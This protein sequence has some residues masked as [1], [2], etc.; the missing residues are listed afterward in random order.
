[1]HGAFDAGPTL[2]TVGAIRCAL[3]LGLLV[4]GCRLASGQ[5]PVGSAQAA[6]FE[7]VSLARSGC[8]GGS[9]P[10]YSVT[11]MGDGTV[12]Y[13]GGV[14]VKTTGRQHGRLSPQP[15]NA[16]TDENGEAEFVV[17]GYA[18][19]EDARE[20]L[21]WSTSPPRFAQLWL[22]EVLETPTELGNITLRRVSPASVPPP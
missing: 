4:A 13:E 2:R 16:R 8:R 15:G 11:V 21:L 1:M 10:A 7:R 14:Y 6:A 5:G 17:Y 3:V 9:C 20:F 12:G 19:N 22:P 18:R